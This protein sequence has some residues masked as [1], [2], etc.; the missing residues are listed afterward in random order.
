MTEAAEIQPEVHLARLV[1]GHCAD[2]TQV[3]VV[4]LNEDPVRLARDQVSA[5]QVLHQ[6]EVEH[7]EV[8][9]KERRLGE[10][11]FP[12]ETVL[13]DLPEEVRQDDRT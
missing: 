8:S 2:M 4:N 7:R 13:E 11:A 9:E 3:R 1:V 12:V 6:V 5:L 10:E